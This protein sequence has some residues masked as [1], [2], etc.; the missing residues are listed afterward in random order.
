MHVALIPHQRSVFATNGDCYGNLQLIK[1]QGTR[2][3]G[4]SNPANTS[5]GQPL[6]LRLRENCR[7]KGVK[8]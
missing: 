5:S 6:N 8:L 1:W 3:F 4:M 7:R 2:G